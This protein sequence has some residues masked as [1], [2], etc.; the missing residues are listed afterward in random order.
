[1]EVCPPEAAD[2]ER[3]SIRHS[4][5][6]WRSFRGLKLAGGEGRR[7]S[8]ECA[9][10]LRA[11]SSTDY[12]NNHSY[13]LARNSTGRDWGAI[14]NWTKRRSL[15]TRSAQRIG[16]AKLP[17]KTV[18][19]K[20]DGE[21]APERKGWL[22][23][24]FSRILTHFES[25]DTPDIPGVPLWSEQVSLPNKEAYFEGD[26]ALCLIPS[27]ELASLEKEPGAGPASIWKV[28]PF[29]CKKCRKEDGKEH[30]NLQIRVDEGQV[31][32]QMQVLC[33]HR[34][35]RAPL[36]R[37]VQNESPGVFGESFGRTRK[38]NSL[39]WLLQWFTL[40]YHPQPHS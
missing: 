5:S 10:V 11:S 20:L 9:D 31:H 22:R 36:P 17:S 4:P 18:G 35:P 2:S 25:D 8:T 14:S 7:R 39:G 16:E 40:C 1:M 13:P 28:T 6:P 19:E 30:V 38:G 26:P 12:V 24:Q 34:F 15:T 23:S 32:V 3:R 37:I 21:S 27:E 33:S 29:I